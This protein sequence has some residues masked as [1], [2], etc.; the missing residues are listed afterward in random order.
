MTFNSQTDD[1][2]TDAAASVNVKVLKCVMLMLV[3]VEAPYVQKM[4][5]DLD[6]YR[7]AVSIK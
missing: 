4:S 6:G 7:R 1:H 5:L 2:V 3:V